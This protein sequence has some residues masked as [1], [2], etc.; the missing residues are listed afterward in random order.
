MH[1]LA[2]QGE[3]VTAERLCRAAHKPAAPGQ[4]PDLRAMNEAI[5]AAVG[6]T[7]HLVLVECCGPGRWIEVRS[8]TVPGRHGE[9]VITARDVTV[10]QRLKDKLEASASAV[11]QLR[12]AATVTD[13][14]AVQLALSDPLT[15]LPNRRAFDIELAESCRNGAF[16]LV[17]LD[18]DRFKAVNDELG[19]VVGDRLLKAVGKEL[20]RQTRVDDFVARLG[21]DEF[22]VVLHDIDAV[23]SVQEAAERLLRSFAGRLDVGDVDLKVG[24]SAGVAIHRPGDDPGTVYREADIALHTAKSRRRGSLVLHVDGATSLAARSDLM[25]VKALLSER[26]VNLS[27][28]PIIDGARNIL[29]HEV[30]VGGNGIPAAAFDAVFATAV[31]FGLGRDLFGAV[32]R[33]VCDATAVWGR[34]GPIHLR[35]PTEAV[36]LEGLVPLIIQEMARASTLPSDLVLELPLAAFGS[37]EAEIVTAQLADAGVGI[38]LGDWDMS[39]SAF[40]TAT[41]GRFRLVAFDADRVAPFLAGGTREVWRA[42]FASLAACNV[43]AC[44]RNVRTEEI[45]AALHDLGV[46][47]VASAR[48]PAPPQLAWANPQ[49]A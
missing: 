47:L 11:R 6:V 2:S 37:D 44:A 35:V 41:E 46:T 48:A 3:P 19:H 12:L 26:P 18:M 20:R 34:H 27:F 22:A 36:A 9:I 23:P 17:I 49:H 25:A 5:R 33:R 24:L 45:A 28:E 14:E 32:F 31:R 7:E 29:A 21:G 42:A 30:L 39:F 10:E 8:L 40:R 13:V 43:A 15:G 16:A 1:D 38:I 4:L